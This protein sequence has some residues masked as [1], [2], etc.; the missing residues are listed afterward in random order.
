[1][2][3]DERWLMTDGRWPKI[4]HMLFVL[5]CAVNSGNYSKSNAL[6]Q[7]PSKTRGRFL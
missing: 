6:G 2:A 4:H 7:R 3:A 5:R 1:M